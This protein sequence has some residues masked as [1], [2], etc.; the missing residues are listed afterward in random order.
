[1]TGARPEVR[2]YCHRPHEEVIIVLH[3]S[4]AI[5]SVPYQLVDTYTLLAGSPSTA[6][7]EYSFAA[8]LCGLIGSLL[9]LTRLLGVSHGSTFDGF[10]NC[11]FKIKYTG[12]FTAWRYKALSDRART[13]WRLEP[14]ASITSERSVPIHL[15][16]VVWSTQLLVVEAEVREITISAKFDSSSLGCAR[17]EYRVTVLVAQRQ[18]GAE[19]GLRPEQQVQQD[20]HRIVSPK[21]AADLPTSGFAFPNDETLNFSQYPWIAVSLIVGG[22]PY[23]TAGWN[24]IFPSVLL[25][26]EFRAKSKFNNLKSAG[27]VLAMQMTF[28]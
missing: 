24:Y 20:H 6:A 11:I 5:S 8:S 13:T 9:P 17:F 16:V 4:I 18:R 3:R 2:G 22:R 15:A 25:P 1:M 27:N 10:V 21:S 7:A 19:Q 14:S 28:V 26:G 23:A 12:L